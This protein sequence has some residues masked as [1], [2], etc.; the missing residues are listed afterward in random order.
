MKIPHSELPMNHSYLLLSLLFSSTPF[1]HLLPSLF[2][3]SA[4]TLSSHHML[5]S[6]T[7]ILVKN[8]HIKRITDQ[9]VKSGVLE[10][11]GTN[12]STNYITCPADPKATLGVK[13]PFL[14]MIIKNLKKYFTFEVQVCHRDRSPIEPPLELLSPLFNCLFCPPASHMYCLCPC[15]HYTQSSVISSFFFYL[16]L[17]HLSLLYLI[18]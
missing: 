18:T 13:L 3:L 10:I 16:R 7:Q 15:F 12:V 2:S 4:F 5:C 6:S 9:D 1:L 11:A 8:G 17:S 14:V